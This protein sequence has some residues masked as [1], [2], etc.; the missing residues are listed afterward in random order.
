MPLN[1]VRLFMYFILNI[2][3]N[4]IF[5]SKIVLLNDMALYD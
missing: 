4:Q 1:H 3:E 2:L 5:F